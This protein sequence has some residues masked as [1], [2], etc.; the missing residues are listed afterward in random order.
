[1]MEPGML[2]LYERA[3][4]PQEKARLTFLG[5]ST[6]RGGRDGRASRQFDSGGTDG[7]IGALVRRAGCFETGRGIFEP[8]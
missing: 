3:G 8:D 2:G 5:L 7:A 1:M 4:A 6:G